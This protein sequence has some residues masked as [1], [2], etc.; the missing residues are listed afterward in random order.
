[1]LW[2]PLQ[3]T[4]RFKISLHVLYANKQ[5]NKH[6]QCIQ[7]H[8]ITY[9]HFHIS[10]M[11]NAWHQL[12]RR[13]ASRF[14]KTSAM[15]DNCN[16]NYQ[17]SPQCGARSPLVCIPLYLH[18][19]SINHPVLTLL[20]PNAS[21]FILYSVFIGV[22]CFPSPQHDCHAGSNTCQH[23]LHLSFSKWF[24]HSASRTKCWCNRKI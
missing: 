11:N 10:N 1:M 2:D 6:T 19:S 18:V 7:K 21:I 22:T 12:I 24:S 8:I 17:H 14:I 5:T 4:Q 9:V 20:L 23:E 16:P 3:N 13:Q 15:K